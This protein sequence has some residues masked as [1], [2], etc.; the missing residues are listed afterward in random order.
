MTNQFIYCL[1]PTGLHTFSC[2]C[3]QYQVAFTIILE[4]YKDVGW[5]WLL[6]MD[7]D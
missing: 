2:H 5:P 3:K 6:E 4:N 1:I 7:L